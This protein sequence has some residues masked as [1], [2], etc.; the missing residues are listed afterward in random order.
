MN[1][2][3][4]IYIVSKGRAD[5]QMTSKALSAMGVPHNVVV[6][7]Q[8]IDA[9]EAAAPD[10]TSF[11]SLPQS[12]KDAY[13]TCDGQAPSPTRSTGSGPARNYAWEH[14]IEHGAAWHWVV[15]DNIHGFTRLVNNQKIP[16]A[17]GTIFAVM[18][19]FAAR[20][21]NVGMAGPNYH[22]FAKRKQVIPPFNANTRIYSC[23]LI[24][25]DIPYRWRAR[26]NE[27]VDLSL[28]ILKGRV[29][30][31]ILF[32]AFLQ[33]KTASQSMKGGNTTELYGAGTLAKSKMI[34]DLHPD[35]ARH[36][37]RFGRRHHYV[38]YRGFQQGL[39]LRDDVTVP[40]G[41]DE[42]GMVLQRKEGEAWVAD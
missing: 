35:V 10:G 29:L 41:P 34:V 4:P 30:C 21:K 16:V 7:P 17:D 40:D 39:V 9:Y 38:D 15:D 27:D 42:F 19:A 23:N 32:N 31:T 6:E 37:W 5:I 33:N 12:Y 1:P 25:N 8:E 22:F 11:L 20:Y 14:S 18:E 2:S 36:L 13:D 3:A 24:R 28:R 26:Y